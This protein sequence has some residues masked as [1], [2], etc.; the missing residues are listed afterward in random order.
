M[1]DAG[2]GDVPTGDQMPTP[3]V[4][5]TPSGVPEV[6]GPAV[7]VPEAATPS[8]EEAPISLEEFQR[9][10]VTEAFH[11]HLFGRLSRRKATP[12]RQKP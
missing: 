5:E 9:R 10:G 12:V 7:Y 6:I 3:A 8:A 11:T 4:L 2:Q 1:I